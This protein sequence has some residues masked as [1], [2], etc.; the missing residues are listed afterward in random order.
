MVDN[1]VQ[2][3]LASSVKTAGKTRMNGKGM[4]GSHTGAS[5]EYE[6]HIVLAQFSR[7]KTLLRFLIVST[8]S[9]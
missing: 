1:G 9:S 4:N 3:T 2:L 6:M 7:G 8:Y 5:I